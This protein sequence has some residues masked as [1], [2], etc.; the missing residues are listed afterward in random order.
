MA[1]AT[2]NT[3]DLYAAWFERLAASRANETAGLAELRTKALAS[4]RKLGFP[5]TRLEDWRWTN[6]AAIANTA[7]E[8]APDA[9]GQVTAD[10]LRPY[11]LDGAATAVVVNGRFAP[12]LSSLAGLPA[13]VT[14]ASL[15]ERIASRDPVVDAHLAKYA[16]LDQPFAALNTALMEDG[17]F[18]HVAKG[19]VCERPIQIL[20]VTTKST[21]PITVQPRSLI[22]VDFN[23]QATVVETFISLGD[24]CYFNNFVTEM[25]GGENAHLD[26]YRYLLESPEAFHIATVQLEQG[27]NGRLDS[28]GFCFE[29]RLTRNDFNAVLNGEGGYCNIDGLYMVREDQHVDNHLVVDHATPHNGSREY[30]KGILEDRG[31]GI[32]SGKIIVREGAQ[33]T[34]AKQTNM[35]LLLSDE[36]QIE[37]KPQLEIFAD[38]VKCTHGATIGQVNTDAI[39][40][41]RTRGIPEEEA[42]SMMIFAFADESIADVR[43]ESL[44]RL[45]EQH[46]LRRLPQAVMLPEDL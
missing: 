39:F 34:D 17:A 37:S 44:K 38:D 27:R 22:V 42:R 28:S 35:S 30:F 6:V 1:L 13:G 11:W 15:A 40:Y 24:E 32:F 9:R 21:K 25:V 2:D 31:R 23:A 10:A 45:L 20:Y 8:P 14:V 46:I 26:H 4:F 16:K 41:L 33:K 19:V 3:I 18:V 5:T 36:A 29:G 43:V 7:F 12:Q